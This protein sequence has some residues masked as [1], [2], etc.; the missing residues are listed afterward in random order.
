MSEA[1]CPRSRRN[2][3]RDRYGIL[4]PQCSVSDYHRCGVL[5]GGLSITRLLLLST[6][7]ELLSGLSTY[8][9]YRRIIADALRAGRHVG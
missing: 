9:I 2:Q 4:S 5:S 1:P 3:L 6:G 7:N 8:C